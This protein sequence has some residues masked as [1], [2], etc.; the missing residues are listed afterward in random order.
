MPEYEVY[1]VERGGVLRVVD[2]VDEID[3][4]A[5]ILAAVRKTFRSPRGKYVA[6][7][8]TGSAEMEIR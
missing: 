4:D 5:A 6:F 2:T 7:A 3:G 8:A 1:A